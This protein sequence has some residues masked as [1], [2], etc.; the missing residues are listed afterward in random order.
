MYY[1]TALFI[2][3]KCNQ[4]WVVFIFEACNNFMLIGGFEFIIFYVL[5]LVYNI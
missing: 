2:Y 5:N 4:I 1:G 3:L